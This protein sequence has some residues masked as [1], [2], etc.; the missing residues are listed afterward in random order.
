M[1]PHLLFIVPPATLSATETG[2]SNDPF[3]RRHCANTAGAA[4]VI[5]S[6]SSLHCCAAF[7]Q[8]R[9]WSGARVFC[10]R[11][12][13]GPD[14]RLLAHIRCIVT[15]RHT[16][17]TYKGATIDL[18]E[19]GRELNVRY[20]LG[21]SV[22]RSGNRLRVNAQLVESESGSHLWAERFDKP[23]A[24]LFDMQ[25]ETVARLANALNAELIAAEALRAQRSIDPDAMDL[26]FQG[27]AI[28][29]KGTTPSTWRRRAAFP[30]EL[31]DQ[32]RAASRRWSPA[33]VWMR[34]QLPHC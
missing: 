4:A 23:V 1:A 25:D 20:V 3:S 29:N 32:T 7:F 10:R 30:K 13:R 18:K 11:R 5:L 8:S 34:Q 19:I 6:T 21:G 24:D 12:H 2:S 28:A 14:H 15:G 26:Y 17:F 9:S 27:V 33:Q 31:W 16:A 22:Q